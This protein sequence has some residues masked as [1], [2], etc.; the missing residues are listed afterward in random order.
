MFSKSYTHS[1]IAPEQL[2]EYIKKLERIRDLLK[3]IA[4]LQ[5]ESVKDSPYWDKVHGNEI[6]C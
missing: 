2:D 6:T 4:T 3:E 5:S 1:T